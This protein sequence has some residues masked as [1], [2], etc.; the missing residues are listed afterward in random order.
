[1]RSMVWGA[2][3]ALWLTGIGW[4]QPAPPAKA[5][6]LVAEEASPELAAAVGALEAPSTRATALTASVT[7]KVVHPDDVRRR[8]VEA[9]APLGGFPT[10]VERQRLVLKVP[11]EGLDRLL[12]EVTGAG[13]LVSKEL[14]RADLIMPTMSSAWSILPSGSII[15]MSGAK[16]RA[17]SIFRV[18]GSDGTLRLTTSDSA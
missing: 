7:L 11:P 17:D 15:S 1:M 2:L 9:A 6:A 13:L 14:S 3:G 18:S 5:T 4:A 16:A 8:L 12:D 10:L